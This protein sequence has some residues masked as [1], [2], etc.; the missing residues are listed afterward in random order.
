VASNLT[1]IGKNMT[2]EIVQYPK[3]KLELEI[4]DVNFILESLGERPA[5]TNA[6]ALMTVIKEQCNPQVPD[7]LK[8]K[9]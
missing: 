5:K 4:A 3:M 6:M 1:L 8:P 2:E 9:E 7:E